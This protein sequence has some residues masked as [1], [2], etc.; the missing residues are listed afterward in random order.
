[1]RAHVLCF[2][3]DMKLSYD[4][5]VTNHLEN[6]IPKGFKRFFTIVCE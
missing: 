3:V 1:M 2:K 5:N 6:Q 4:T